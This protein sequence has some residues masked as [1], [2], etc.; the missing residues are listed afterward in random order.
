[1]T[2]AI[3]TPPRFNARLHARILAQ[4]QVAELKEPFAKAYPNGIPKEYNLCR[5][6]ADE[7][8]IKY[9]EDNLPL[10]FYTNPPPGAKATFSTGRGERPFRYMYHI[11][12]RRK[13]HLWS[14]NEIQQNCNSIRKLHWETMRT[15][16][17]PQCW[18]DLWHYFD[19]FDL[20]NHG[21]INLWNMINHLYAENK[22]IYVD[23]MKTCALELGRWADQW[24]EIK[25]NANRLKGW[26]A[27]KGPVIQI[28]DE[29]DWASL[30]SLNDDSIPLLSNALKHRRDHLLS[31]SRIKSA[32]AR[33]LQSS[34]R[35]EGGLEN[36]MTGQRIHPENGLQQPKKAEAMDGK[37]GQHP[38]T[39]VDGKHYYN[40]RVKSKGA[41]EALKASV[42]AASGPI[43]VAHGSKTSPPRY[44]L[45][46]KTAANKDANL[47]KP[48]VDT[49]QTRPNSSDGSSTMTTPSRGTSMSM[50]VSPRRNSDSTI[51][52]SHFP[53][54]K[55]ALTPVTQAGGIAA[56]GNITTIL[57]H[58][59]SPVSGQ[60]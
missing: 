39:I 55:A 59:R 18:D 50:S 48:S 1:M 6:T 37:P 31:P 29:Q 19:A 32:D 60:A 17:Q 26:Q 58:A 14:K 52:P 8:P 21:A 16:N 7:I 24:L 40:P 46:S 11:L 57:S 53:S 36:W 47:L 35:S 38:C 56:A 28:L 43:V 42:E 33:D 13:L 45:A 20:Y 23:V 4:D 51:R 30:G 5:T 9:I 49:Q 15:M 44:P 34:S 12:P 10:G 22:I 41:V 54:P 3:L 27:T 2:E 25:G